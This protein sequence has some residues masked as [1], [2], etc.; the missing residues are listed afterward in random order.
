MLGS[1]H[2]LPVMCN[3]DFKC[4]FACFEVINGLIM[5]ET[6][7]LVAG[8]LNLPTMYYKMNGE[9]AFWCFLNTYL[10]I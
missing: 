1:L 3:I 8:L 2:W 5:F 6:A 9:A 10:Y 4:I 7:P